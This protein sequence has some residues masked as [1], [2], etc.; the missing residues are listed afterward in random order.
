VHS[1]VLFLIAIGR[2]SVGSLDVSTGWKEGSNLIVI[3]FQGLSQ[4]LGLV[5][6]L[7][8]PFFLNTEKTLA[9]C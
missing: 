3:S 8:W 5:S 4:I 2:S 6:I 9:S 1:L 7:E